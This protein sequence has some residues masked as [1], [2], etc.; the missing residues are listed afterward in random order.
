MSD[1]SAD[2]MFGLAFEQAGYAASGLTSG[3]KEVLV[4]HVEEL[5]REYGLGETLNVAKT[6]ASEKCGIDLDSP[7]AESSSPAHRCAKECGAAAMSAIIGGT[8]NSLE[9]LEKV[10]NGEMSGKDA[11]IKI[12][13]E[14]VASAADSAL[15]AAG[16]TGRKI[17]I[18]KYGSEENALKAF[19]EQGMQILLDNLPVEQGGKRIISEM[20]QL[21][22]ISAGKIKLDGALQ[23]APSLIVQSMPGVNAFANMAGS[24]A[25]DLVKAQFPNLAK[26]LPKHPAVLAA[27]IVAIVGGYIAVKN[28]IERPYRDL[29]RN[30]NTLRE[31]AAE[32]DKISNNLFKGQLLFGKYLE[33][34]ARLETQFRDHMDAI[35]KS[36]KQALD[37]ILKI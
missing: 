23:N 7:C 11:V 12:V 8:A 34:D 16:E 1:I 28:G 19:A 32:L 14:T 25:L 6:I 24:G 4:S 35:D 29:L 37:A 33:S 2:N 13:G 27:A 18:E 31:A 20:L 15:K 9:Y 5:A 22:D 3:A 10:R 36:G 30:T 21:V 17:I 26:N